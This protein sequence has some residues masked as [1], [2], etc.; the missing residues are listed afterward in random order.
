MKLDKEQQKHVVEAI[1]KIA[2]IKKLKV[3]SY[4]I[5]TV[6]DDIFIHSDFF[7]DSEKI[8]YR[9]YVK[10]YEY[11]DIFWKV[12]QMP[13][14]ST[15]KDSIRAIGAFKAPSILLEE[16]EIGLTE[17]YEEQVSE[18]INMILECSYKF[19]KNYNIDEYVINS[20]EELDINIL[21]Y[22]AYIHLDRKEDARN[23]AENALRAGEKGR[24]SNEGKYFFEWAMT[25]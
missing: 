22:L 9:I 24:F 18:F 3:K 21:K 13:S 14:N 4:A 11:D 8:S 16:G 25:L 10:Y 19:I 7:V 12:M 20:S 5:Y 23:V 6:E 15:Q 17:K 2:K 1:R